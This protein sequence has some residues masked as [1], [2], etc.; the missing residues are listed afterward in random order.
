MLRPTRSTVFVSFSFAAA[1]LFGGLANAQFVSSKVASGA[2]GATI[3]NRGPVHFSVG[4]LNHDGFADVVTADIRTDTLTSMMS[5]GGL[6]LIAKAFPLT[7]RS[8]TTWVC[9]GNMDILNDKIL[10]VMSSPSGYPAIDFSQGL[11][12]GAFK[13]PHSAFGVTSLSP[14]TAGIVDSDL[15]GLPDSVFTIDLGPSTPGLGGYAKGNAKFTTAGTCVWSNFCPFVSVTGNVLYTPNSLALGDITGTAVWGAAI[16]CFNSASAQIRTAPS[17]GV[18]TYPTP[19]YPRSVALGDLDGDR[20]LD[21]AVACLSAPAAGVV[22]YLSSTGYLTQYTVPY[23]YSNG[24]QTVAVTIGDVTGDGQ[25]DIVVAVCQRPVSPATDFGIDSGIINQGGSIVDVY[26]MATGTPVLASSTT[27][28]SAKGVRWISIN[29][30]D[31]DGKNDV[32]IVNRYSNNV[33]I[34]FNQTPTPVGIELK[35]CGT[36]GCFG[37]LGMGANSSPQIGNTNFR[38]TCT[39]APRNKVGVVLLSANPT[40]GPMSAAFSNIYGINLCAEYDLSFA[41]ATYGSLWSN[42]VGD[43]C[44]KP[45]SIPNNPL[46][47]GQIFY[48]QCV[49]QE[50]RADGYACSTSALDI[51]ASKMLKVTI[52]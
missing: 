22:Y 1:L 2:V 19:I 50:D 5:F 43:G 3:E 9:V 25:A 11:G 15:D 4:D 29:D 51:V 16:T 30:I 41:L 34:L 32:I 46:F 35:L 37:R 28:P 40:P 8:Q 10:D 48:V 33:S 31:V 44:T 39:N 13:G 38:F 17:S 45:L 42:S 12:T 21:F 6:G 23:T 27:V 36:H 49:F 20:I 26:D 47:I 52:Q 7:V 18:T 24:E 14:L